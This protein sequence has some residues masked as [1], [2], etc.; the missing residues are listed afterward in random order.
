MKKNILLFLIPLFFFIAADAQAQERWVEDFCCNETN[1]YAKILGGVN[2]LQNTTIDG[3][4][5][6][7]KTGYIV[8][9]SLGYV[10]RYGICLE[11]EYAYRRNAIKKLEFV[12]EDTSNS[13]HFRTS[14]C[15]ANLIWELPLSAWGCAF[16]NIQPFIGAGIGAD[17]QKMHSVNPRIIFDQKWNCFAWQAMAGLAYPIFCNTKL[18]LEYKYHQGNHFKNQTVG[19]GLAYQFGFLR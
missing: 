8:A 18:S 12:N 14:S 15:M 2:F 4:E 3:N 6:S 7:Y 13:G 19:V 11:L 10:W 1:F 17:F 5:A 16:G 9:G